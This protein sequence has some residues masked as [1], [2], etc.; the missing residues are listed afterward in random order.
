MTNS[1]I[2][3]KRELLEL[4]R[5]RQLYIF[6]DGEPRTLAAPI[7]HTA[8]GAA[9][10][11]LYTALPARGRGYAKAAIEALARTLKERGVRDVYLYADPANKAAGAIAEKLGF[12]PIADTV[13][14]AFV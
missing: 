3:S 5:A 1:N 10:G 7:R 4:L 8:T 12:R 13:D 9:I 14:I 6:E 11:V 2:P